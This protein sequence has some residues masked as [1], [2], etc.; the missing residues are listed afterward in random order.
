MPDI[1]LNM[2][3]LACGIYQEN[4]AFVVGRGNR[5]CFGLVAQVLDHDAHV[6]LL[7]DALYV[8]LSFRWSQFLHLVAQLLC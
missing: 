3:M 5:I 6:S 1:L 8:L 2:A 7:V 4:V